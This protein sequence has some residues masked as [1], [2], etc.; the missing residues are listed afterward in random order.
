MDWSKYELLPWEKL[1]VNQPPD[2]LV[3]ICYEIEGHQCF[4]LGSFVCESNNCWRWD[5]TEYIPLDDI[6]AFTVIF[7]PKKDY[8]LEPEAA[9]EE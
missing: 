8:R 9:G 3:L 6:I 7:G 4:D 5:G 1:D 2:D